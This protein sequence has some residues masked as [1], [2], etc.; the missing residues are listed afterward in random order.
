MYLDL[1]DEARRK[2]EFPNQ[3]DGDVRARYPVRVSLTAT[4]VTN[5]L[6]GEEEERQQ[7]TVE[8]VG[9]G[10]DTDIIHQ[11]FLQVGRSYYTTDEFKRRFAFVPGSRFG[12][13]FLSVFAVSD[14]VIVE[15]YKPTS[16]T[17]TVPLRLTLYGPRKYLLTERFVRHLP[18]TKIQILLRDSLPPGMLFQ[19]VSRWCRRVEFPILVQEPGEDIRRISAEE[20]DDFTYTEPI[21]GS[22]GQMVSVRAFPIQ[23]PGIFGELY[24]LS[25]QD[26]S[27][28]SWAEWHRLKY[29]PN[30]D[31][32]ASEPRLPSTLHCLHGITL[33]VESTDERAERL[34]FRA[35]RFQ[36]TLSR[37]GA[38]RPTGFAYHGQSQR[39]PE[40]ESRW[41]EILTLIRK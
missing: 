11:Y 18:G 9:I 23:R 8:D 26:E 31:P 2:V 13:G 5:E 38:R 14:K 37:E 29:R 6:S 30:A 40:V 16:T 20:P 3:I 12:V 25:Y 27:G 34:D 1:D 32:R 24:V 41:V 17:R 7:L 10:M 28:E 22:T 4:S 33:G 19:L 21:P 39:L 15:T 35:E 36:S